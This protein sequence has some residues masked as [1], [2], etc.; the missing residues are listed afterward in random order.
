MKIT[1]CERFDVV[2]ARE[3]PVD[4]YRDGSRA[5]MSVGWLGVMA[6]DAVQLQA[7]S[8]KTSE[9]E[10]VNAGIVSRDIHAKHLECLRHAAAET[11]HTARRRYPQGGVRTHQISA[12]VL[13]ADVSCLKDSL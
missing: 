8:R 13:I 12:H 7:S 5:A 1:H 6:L 2:H 4:R 9:T 11:T 10:R 3:M